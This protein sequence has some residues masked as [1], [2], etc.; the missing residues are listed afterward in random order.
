MSQAQ[1]RLICRKNYLSQDFFFGNF[2]FFGIWVG[3][4]IY[5]DANW[6]WLCFGI[7]ES[8]FD[9]AIIG[10]YDFDFLNKQMG[11]N[12]APPGQHKHFA[13]SFMNRFDPWVLGTFIGHVMQQRRYVEVKNP[14]EQVAQVPAEIFYRNSS[15]DSSHYHQ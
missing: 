15:V 3:G 10:V 4:N 7:T 11:K 5:L 1:S 2:C 14:S 6:G 13:G 12:L 8:C 9:D